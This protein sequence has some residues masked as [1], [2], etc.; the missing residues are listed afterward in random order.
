[1]KSCTSE[2]SKLSTFVLVKRVNRVPLQTPSR[3]DSSNDET[4]AFHDGFITSFFWVVDLSNK[5][6]APFVLD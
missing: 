1:M 6:G 2:A 3:L 5:N 4:V